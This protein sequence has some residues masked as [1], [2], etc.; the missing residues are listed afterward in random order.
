MPG[1]VAYATSKA[2]IAGLVPTAAAELVRYGIRLNAINPG[3]VNTGY[4]DTDTTDRSTKVIDDVLATMPLGRF[5]VPDDVAHLVAWL[6][7]DAGRWVT[8][9]VITSDGGFT[10]R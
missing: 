8:G 6:V 9:Q 7:S 5:G 10:L 3:P 4:L 2:A 1:E